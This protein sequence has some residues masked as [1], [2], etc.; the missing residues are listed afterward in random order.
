MPGA[1][2]LAS[3]QVR[4][5]RARLRSRPAAIRA[6]RDDNSQVREQKPHVLIAS[7]QV[8]AVLCALPSAVVIK[9]AKLRPRGEVSQALRALA[10][11][12]RSDGSLP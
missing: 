1:V 4:H 10:A 3:A 5:L 12:R 9:P 6:L 7:P 8:A 11:P 2:P